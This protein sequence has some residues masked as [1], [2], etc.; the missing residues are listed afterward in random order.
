[1]I[2]LCRGLNGNS[3]F[4]SIIS[5]RRDFDKKFRIIAVTAF[6]HFFRVII[7]FIKFKRNVV[8]VPLHT[9]HFQ[10]ARVFRFAVER[11]V[12]VHIG[13][14][15][16]FFAGY[17]HDLTVKRDLNGIYDL[18]DGARLNHSISYHVRSVLRSDIPAPPSLT[19]GIGYGYLAAFRYRQ[20]GLQSE[21]QGINSAFLKRTCKLC[22][23]C[24][25]LGRIKTGSFYPI[26][27]I[28]HKADFIGK[29]FVTVYSYDLNG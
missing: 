27:L 5:I 7:A 19:V 9:E 3:H 12:V 2:G 16:S 24:S 1:M 28:C 17:G 14:P 8:K 10:K 15:R 20:I 29:G 26:E 23:I 13:N 18:I 22:P 4:V 21:M 25:P 6:N 11:N